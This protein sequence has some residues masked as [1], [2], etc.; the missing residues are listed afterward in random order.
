MDPAGASGA[1][2]DAKTSFDLWLFSAAADKASAAFLQTPFNERSARIS[3]DGHRVMFTSDESGE[4]E[5]YI[6]TF[7]VAGR[8]VRVS[9]DGGSS[10]RWRDDG[11]EVFF[12]S[13]GKLMAAT[14]VADSAAA[15]GPRLGV[16]RALFELPEGAG[17][18]LPARG[19]QR[20]LV[21]IEVAKAVPSPITVV[22]N[23]HTLADRQ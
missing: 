10:P 21:N 15:T 4:D 5:V 17:A 20:F 2:S 22:L 16:L 13:A 6:T 9:T 7:P 11:A 8:R 12:A 18:W 23:W 3:P 19:G 1:N 14:V